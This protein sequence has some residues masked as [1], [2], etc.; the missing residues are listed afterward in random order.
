MDENIV[1]VGRKP[2][3]AYVTAIITKINNGANAVT[4]K[5][6]GKAISTAVDAAEIVRA[7]FISDLKLGEIRIY[8]E[9]VGNENE[10][11]PSRVSAIEIA[12]SK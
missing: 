10:E 8:T 4:L 2:P 9:E 7:R 6:R 5:A 1:L 3:M 11:R 12:L